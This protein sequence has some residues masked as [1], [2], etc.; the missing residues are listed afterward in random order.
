M[1][2]NRN[3]TERDLEKELRE[4]MAELS[5][6]VDCFDKISA[7][8][9]PEKNSD[10]YESELTESNLENITGKRRA[11]PVLKWLAAAAAVV[12]CVGVLPRTMFFQDFLTNLGKQTDNKFRNIISEI[13]VETN[14]HSYKVYDMS[15]EDYIKYDILFDPISGCPFGKNE[16]DDIN[17]RVYVRTY[18]DIPTNQIYAVEYAGEYSDT[19]IIAAAETKAKFTDEELNVLGETLD[20]SCHDEAYTV[21]ANIFT[22]DKYA[23]LTDTDGKR[24]TGA[25][26]SYPNICKFGDEVKLLMTQVIYYNYL[27]NSD[28]YYYD[29]FSSCYDDET[30]QYIV[31]TLP[32]AKEL[33]KLSVDYDGTDAM[34]K[35]ALSAFNKKDIFSSLTED[36]NG[37]ELSWF[38]PY[39]IADAGLVDDKIQTFVHYGSEFRTPADREMKQTLRMYEPNITHFV[40]S[41][42]SDPTIEISI[43]GRNEKIIVHNSDINGPFADLGKEHDTTEVSVVGDIKLDSD[44]YADVPIFSEKTT[45]DAEESEY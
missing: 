45:E 13:R 30:D 27:D 5:S 10:F 7:R 33:W 20:F 3:N 36:D 16:N 18:S 29:T 19:N 8:A 31:F 35:S 12:I 42:Q 39:N 28:E 34:S 41:S 38:E 17:V 25:S 1:K 2:D 6:N 22:S 24:V 32:E 21:A 11:A 44:V 15:L 40:Y 9:F 26:Y 4:K 43:E 37:S 23:Y 14:T